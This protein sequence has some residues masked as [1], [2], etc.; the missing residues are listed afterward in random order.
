VDAYG[1]SEQATG[2]YTM[3]E[4]DLCLP[5]ETEMLG[6]TVSVESEYS[7]PSGALIPFEVGQDSVVMW[8]AIPLGC[9]A[10]IER[11]R[12]RAPHARNRAPRGP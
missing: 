12:N 4:N 11:E 1:E 6:V 10:R 2:F 5:F 3:I 8:G 7:G 9:G